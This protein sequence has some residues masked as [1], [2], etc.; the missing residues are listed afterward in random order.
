MSIKKDEYV[1]GDD[2]QI[3]GNSSYVL[4][5]SD[6]VEERDWMVRS[7]VCPL[8]SQHHVAHSG[9]LK[10]QFPFEIVRADQSG[11]YMMA[12]FGGEGRVLVDGAWKTVRSGEACLLPP[13]VRNA[14]KCVEGKHW[15]FCWVRY[16]ESRERKPIVS[17]N[18]P[19]LKNYD[20]APLRSAIEGL[21]AETRGAMNP[22]VL[23]HW[24]EL[25]HQYTLRFAQPHD[26]D[27]RLWR[28]WNR[29]EPEL[30]RK[31]SLF[32]LSEIAHVSEEHLRRLCRK[33]YG[34]SP[35][36]HLTFLR[37]QRAKNLLSSTDEKIETI[38]HLVGYENPFT[39]SSL[40]KKW[41]GWSPSRYR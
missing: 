3:L 25:V 23:G 29:V 15:E 8:L 18:S 19:V 14:F 21:Y 1:M 11:S 16:L 12:C 37:I 33:R 30:E 22:G 36:Q 20:N 9:I 31:W 32:E 2:V 6:E 38:A 27:D 28:L 4:V 5:R 17:Q 7:P 10:A 13:F 39:F 26:S 40:F 41:V 35:M 24:V 34:R